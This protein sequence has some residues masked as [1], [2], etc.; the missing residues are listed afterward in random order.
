MFFRQCRGQATACTSS[1]GRH[2]KHWQWQSSARLYPVHATTGMVM[3]SLTLQLL[4]AHSMSGS[5]AH[6]Q[7]VGV[8]TRLALEDM[9][10][11]M[12]FASATATHTF[13]D[14]FNSAA[15]VTDPC[16]SS[17]PALRMEGITCDTYPGGDI[18]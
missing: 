2:Q 14:A 1:G 13:W 15:S 18:T 12:G 4:M 3:V 5:S 10:S 9:Y 17:N 7:A 6:A 11:S 16:A 8:S